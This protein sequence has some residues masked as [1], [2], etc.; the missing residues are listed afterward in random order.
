MFPY[1]DDN[2]AESFPLV[3]ILLIVVNA[4]IFLFLSPSAHYEEIIRQFGFI[5][6]RG[7]PLTFLTSLFLHANLLHLVF[8]MWYL[9]LFGD[10]LEDRFGKL[11]FLFFYL[12]GGA[13]SLLLHAWTVG[14]QMKEIPCIGA[15][16]AISAVMG[17]YVTL[18][19]RANI[20]VL[21]LFFFTIQTF[22][23]SALFFLGFWFLQQLLLT[24]GS[25]NSEMVAPV[26]YGAHIGGFVFGVVFASVIKHLFP[27]KGN[28]I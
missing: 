23:I 25:T 20:Q 18:F 13:F 7:E 4:A 22:K 12:L 17:G 1:R 10:N 14:P 8:N 28:I 21:F 27:Q 24:A 26:A 16:G 15:S 19:P 11:N 6:D 3:A 9:W 5:P 2:P